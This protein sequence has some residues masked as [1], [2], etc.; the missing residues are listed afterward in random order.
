LTELDRTQKL[1]AYALGTF[2]D[3]RSEGLVELEPLR[4]GARKLYEKIKAEFDPDVDELLDVVE[5]LVLQG[6]A[7]EHEDLSGL[8]EAHWTRGAP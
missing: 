4:P 6:Q 7:P 1:V 8:V 2:D 3:L 5:H